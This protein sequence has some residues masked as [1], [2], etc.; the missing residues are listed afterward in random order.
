MHK[1]LALQAMER[2]EWLS[3]DR[4]VQQTVFA[5]GTRLIANFAEAERSAEGIKLPPH[6]V[7]ALVDGKVERVFS[8]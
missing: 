4:L 6:S 2:F 1:R 8:A 7:T 5:D 3:E